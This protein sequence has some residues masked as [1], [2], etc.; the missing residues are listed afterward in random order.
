MIAFVGTL[1]FGMHRS[2]SEGVQDNNLT[3]EVLES[4]LK[5]TWKVIF[6]VYLTFVLVYNM[7]LFAK[8]FRIGD[9]RCDVKVRSPVRRGEPKIYL[10]NGGLE[11]LS[12]AANKL[13]VNFYL[14]FY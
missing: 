2:N 9:F 11:T 6:P 7:N 8:D 14:N 10:P 13:L 5:C 1:A 4:I 3:I 12:R